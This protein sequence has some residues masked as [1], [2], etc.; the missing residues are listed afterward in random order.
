[1]CRMFKRKHQVVIFY[2]RG[3]NTVAVCPL[4]DACANYNGYMMSFYHTIKNVNFT[5]DEF[6]LYYQYFTPSGHFRPHISMYKSNFSNSR[7]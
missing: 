3:S 6:R 7:L 2:L 1:M 5:A 4:V